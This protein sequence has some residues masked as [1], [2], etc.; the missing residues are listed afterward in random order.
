M[1]NLVYVY[2]YVIIYYMARI[3]PRIRGVIYDTIYGVIYGD[4]VSVYSLTRLRGVI[5]G[6]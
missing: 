2:G 5:Y 1:A 3:Y 4:Y 6:V